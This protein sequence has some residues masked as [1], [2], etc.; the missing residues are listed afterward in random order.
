MTAGKKYSINFTKGNTIFCLSLY[1]NKKKI[2]IY[3]LMVQR[4]I[5]SKEKSTKDGQ[6]EIWLGNIS[7]GFPANNMKKTGLYGNVCD[8]SVDFT[9]IVVNNI[10][11]IHKYLMEK[12]SVK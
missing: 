5:N 11:D 1:H 8:F 4:F 3:L 6:T 9:S 7:T 12:N 2:V 10:L